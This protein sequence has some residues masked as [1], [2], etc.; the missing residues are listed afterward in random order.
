[1]SAEEVRGPAPDASQDAA[2]AAGRPRL[3]AEVITRAAIALVDADGLGSF[4]MRRL[5]DA[6]GVRAMALYR[7]FPSRADMVD[8]VVE[9]VVDELAADPEVTLLP[10]DGWADYVTR[11]AHGFRRVA[12]THPR[13][14]PLVATHPSGAP[15]L[16]PPIRSL[17]WVDALLQGLG[18]RDFSPPAAAAAYKTLS[19]FLLGHLLVEVAGLGHEH[20]PGLTAPQQGD[21]VVDE[22][23]VKAERRRPR[24]AEEAA[25]LLVGPEAPTTEDVLG[26]PRDALPSVASS[27]VVQALD[28]AVV[29]AGGAAGVAL[30]ADV[31]V[32]AA[33]VS[34]AAL[35][36]ADYPSLRAMAGLLAM[37]TAAEEFERGLERV[38]GQL[39][40]LHEVRPV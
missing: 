33:V 23:E 25:P 5:A 20:A 35:D 40:V 26:A 15:W 17:R 1:V 30:D 37:D 10:T 3:S 29:A 39:T 22:D 31:P 6:L 9:A 13:L 12:L 8:A 7:Y 21:D 34:T 32:I 27:P 11:L 4:T 36:L 38:L 28:P 14:F 18:S 19:T 24:R 16:R 2:G